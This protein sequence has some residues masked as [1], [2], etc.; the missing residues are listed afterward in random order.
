MSYI[1]TF[2]DLPNRDYHDAPAV[3]SSGLKLV[4]QSPLHYWAQYLDPERERTEPTPAQL[5]GTAWHAAIFEPA[6]FEAEFVQIPD[7]LD[8]RTKEGKAL[9]AELQASGRTP[10]SADDYGRVL[11][12]RD[13]ARRH[14]VTAAIF[15]Q[16]GGAAEHSLFWI[17]PATGAHCKIRPDFAVP[18][19]AMFPHGLLVDGKTGEDM[20]TAGFAKYAMNWKL[21]LQAAFY[22]DGFQ[23]V[24]GTSEPPAFVW[25]AQEKSTP[26]ATAYYSAASDFLEFGRRQYRRALATWA[27][28]M[29]RNEWPG[30]STGVQPLELP[31]WAAKQI[32]EG[33]AA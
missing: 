26:Y 23:A 11:A 25:L 2:P 1:G 5:L 32:S 14:P 20:S 24:H 18:P 27:Q 9:W 4:L 22:A 13:S 15:A 30:Y 8:R 28:C 21:A 29:E 19:C 31:A 16:A 33:V 17:D 3:G 10:L 7:G 6:K 12:M